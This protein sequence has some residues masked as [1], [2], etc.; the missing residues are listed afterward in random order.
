M[1]LKLHS[2]ATLK[3]SFKAERSFRELVTNSHNHS[4]KRSTILKNSSSCPAVESRLN[5]V[6][7]CSPQLPEILVRWSVSISYG[8]NERVLSMDK[9]L[10]RI[11]I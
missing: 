8:Q 11:H 7:H 10:P 2:L 1:T 3:V 9:R 5:Y 6:L 4:F